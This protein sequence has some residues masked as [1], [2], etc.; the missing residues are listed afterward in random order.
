MYLASSGRPTDIGLWARPATFA[1]GKGKKGGAVFLLLLFLHFHSFSS[2][3][4]VPRFQ[5]FYYLS[6]P[7]LRET[8]QNGQQGLTCR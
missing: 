1:A 6:S 3:S 4:H 7:F 5:L 8:T 2:F